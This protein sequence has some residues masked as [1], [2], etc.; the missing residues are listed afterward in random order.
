MALGRIA[1]VDIGDNNNSTSRS[2]PGGHLPEE[3]E[4]R[5]SKLPTR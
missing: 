2:Q 4:W 3:F 1:A 5:E